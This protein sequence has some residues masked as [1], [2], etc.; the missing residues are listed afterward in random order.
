VPWLA[1]LDTVLGLTDVARRM[2]RRSLPVED[3][4][5]TSTPAAGG[6]LEARLAGVVVAALKEAFDR[7]H[8]R[9]QIER[10]Q[11]EAERRRAERTLNLELARQA[12]ERELARMRLLTAIGGGTWLVT[13]FLS[14]S[15]D[16]WPAAA[17]IVLGG[18][19]L[20]LLIGI[21]LSFVVQTRVARALDRVAKQAASGGR[22][23]EVLAG[24]AGT[25]ATC[26]IALGLGVAAAALLL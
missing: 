11:V 14:R 2:R 22:A 16:E 15:L 10:E 25:A 6:A 20:L 19:W 23:E 17:R 5:A 8:E 12:G 18:G 26:L 1:I 24:S 21:T 9:L 13:A 4:I 7:D 3:Q